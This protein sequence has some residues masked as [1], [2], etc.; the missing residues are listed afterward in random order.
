MSQQKW[1]PRP[2]IFFLFLIRF[3]QVNGFIAWLINTLFEYGKICI[4]YF[5]LTW[6]RPY[7]TI[8]CTAL[9]CTALYCNCTALHCTARDFAAHCFTVKKNSPD[10][11]VLDCTALDCTSPD[12]N[13]PNYAVRTGLLCTRTLLQWNLTNLKEWKL[14]NILWN[15]QRKLGLT[16]ITQNISRWL[17]RTGKTI[18][19]LKRGLR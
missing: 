10:C 14:L 2:Y 12:C 1:F 19:L 7:L 4:C 15:F 5:K 16:K 13:E 9:Y 8:H 11:I 17:K 3:Q 6:P 18:K